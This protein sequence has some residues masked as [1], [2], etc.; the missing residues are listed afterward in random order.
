MILISSLSLSPEDCF[1]DIYLF[2]IICINNLKIHYPRKQQHSGKR[3]RTRYH[4]Y[5][6]LPPAQ[7]H[8]RT[9]F[10]PK[11]G[12]VNSAQF[13]LDGPL[14]SNES[15]FSPSRTPGVSDCPVGPLDFVN[16]VA[17]KENYVVHVGFSGIA[18]VVNAASVGVPG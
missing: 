4:T 10:H 8:H 17:N 18:S 2:F 5:R 13:A 16:S 1:R 15:P 3:Y 12:R 9:H 11:G 14:D 7:G 6:R